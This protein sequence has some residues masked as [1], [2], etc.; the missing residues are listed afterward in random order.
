MAVV[1]DLTVTLEER[2][3]ILDQVDQAIANIR[4]LLPT[5]KPKRRQRQLRLPLAEPKKKKLRCGA[6]GG[7]A[8]RSA[9]AL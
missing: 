3:R 2:R 4:G 8:G 5:T 7:R 1:I 9:C 6:T